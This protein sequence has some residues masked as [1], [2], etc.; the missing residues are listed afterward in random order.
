MDR[1]EII[2]D[3]V[4]V[5]P[6]K[7]ADAKLAGDSLSSSSSSAAAATTGTGIDIIIAVGAYIGRTP[8]SGASHQ[9]L[10]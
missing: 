5:D 2:I 9:L 4:V 1:D 3:M 7:Y 6:K 8:H 10:T